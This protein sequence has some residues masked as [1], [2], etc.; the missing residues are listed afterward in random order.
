M[1]YAQSINRE[2]ERQVQELRVLRDALAS[3]PLPQP[4][5]SAWDAREILLHLIGAIREMPNDLKASA[6]AP[7]T[8]VA[9]RQPGGRYVDIPEIW[10]ASDAAA[11]LLQQLDAIAEAVRDLDDEALGRPATVM[12]GAGNPIPNVSIGLVVRHGLREHFDEHVAQLREALA[13]ARPG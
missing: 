6:P 8:V 2:I 4:G 5:T 3:T 7:Q 1:T 9:S 13:P 12:D 11:A 10:T